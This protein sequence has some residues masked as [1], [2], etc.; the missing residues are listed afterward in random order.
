M[1][2][3]ERKPIFTLKGGFWRPKNISMAPVYPSLTTTKTKGT[4]KLGHVYDAA[5]KK[6]I[7]ENHLK[8]PFNLF[9]LSPDKTKLKQINLK[10]IRTISTTESVIVDVDG[11]LTKESLIRG[12]KSYT[13]NK[14]KHICLGDREREETIH[15]LTNLLLFTPGFN[16][17]HKEILHYVL[18]VF[19]EGQRNISFS[20][21]ISGIESYP[22]KT[23]LEIKACN[24]LNEYMRYLA[25]LEQREDLVD[26]KSLP[27]RTI[28]DLSSIPFSSIKTFLVLF[29]LVQL[30]KS[31]RK[32]ANI[33]VSRTQWFNMPPNAYLVLK[34]VLSILKER[35]NNLVIGFDNM[36]TIDPLIISVAENVALLKMD[37]N[38][39]KKLSSYLQSIDINLPSFLRFLDEECII[40]LSKENINPTLIVL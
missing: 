28:I 36:E 18:A 34:D 7:G 39:N 1:E 30:L 11:I 19:F 31:G 24:E 2:E 15:L 8:E 6:F 5:R 21:M 33:I 37:V 22:V 25:S 17:R 27:Q 16:S 10:L 32:N 12:Y 29:I 23:P 38:S 4:F 40:L 35:S 20:D 14:L 3:K 13:W 9:V 26:F